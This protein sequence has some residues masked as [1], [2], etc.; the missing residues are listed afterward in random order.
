MH[1]HVC[2]LPPPDAGWDAWIGWIK[3]AMAIDACHMVCRA[4]AE[5]AIR[6]IWVSR[7]LAGEEAEM[8]NAVWSC[9]FQWSCWQL[10]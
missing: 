1:E 10:P 2:D 8:G 6:E 4:A 5:L 3:R 9:L 7:K